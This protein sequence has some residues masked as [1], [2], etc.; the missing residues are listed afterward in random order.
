MPG[1]PFAS[2]NTDATLSIGKPRDPVIITEILEVLATG[3]GLMHH[4]SSLPQSRPYP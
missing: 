1:E 2:R 3:L 4:T